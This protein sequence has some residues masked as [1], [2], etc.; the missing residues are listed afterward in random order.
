MLFLRRGYIYLILLLITACTMQQHPHPFEQASNQTAFIERM[1]SYGFDRTQVIAILQQAEIQPS[2][3]DA[4][5][6]PHEAKPWY[7][8][9]Q[10]F[11]TTDRIQHGRQ[12]MQHHAA[13]LA[14]AEREYGVPATVITAI[15]GVETAYGKRQ[16]NYRVLDALTTLAF[17][18]PPRASFFQGELANYLLLSRDQN[19]D[20]T[21]IQGSYA[22]A[23]GAAQFM[24]SAYLHYAVSAAHTKTYDLSHNLDDA[25]V[26]IANY[27]AKNGWQ[28]NQPIAT[29]ARA[30]S[31]YLSGL[32]VNKLRPKLALSEWQQHGVTSYLNLPNTTP[33]SLFE[34]Q[35][36]HGPEYW[37]GL[38]NFY[39]I[40][41]YNPRVNYAM[42]V[43][44]LSQLLK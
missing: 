5:T 33:V 6:T 2:I 44:Q 15:L 7:Q 38:H 29:R 42:A 13:I 28:R 17:N 8:Y 32:P 4:I 24:P 10:T 37:L 41:S 43:F 9:R 14:Q 23:F 30:E 20:P 26:S 11:L 1:Q 18:Y 3:I 27:L 36:V 34:L 39:V 25:I 35:G 40:S 16:G 19:W 12:F 21:S 22:G 31:P